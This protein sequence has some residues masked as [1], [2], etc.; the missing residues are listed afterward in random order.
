MNKKAEAKNLKIIERRP[1]IDPTNLLSGFSATQLIAELRLRGFTGKL[2]FV[3][4][5]AI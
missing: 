2:S 5:V 1:K 4:E 3:Q